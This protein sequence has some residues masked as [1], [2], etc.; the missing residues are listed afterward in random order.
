M[1]EPHL[2]VVAFS[3]ESFYEALS[4]PHTPSSQIRKHR[5]AQ[6]LFGY[7]TRLGAVSLVSEWPYTDGDYLD[8]FANYYVKCH[9]SYERRCKRL[10]FFRVEI[11]DDRLRLRIRARA[12]PE[13]GDDPDYLGFIVARPLPSAVVGRTV[14][15][16]FGDDGGRRNYTCKRGYKVNLCGVELEFDSLAFQEQDTILAACATV[17]LWSCFQ[18]TCNLFGTTSPTPA[19]ITNAASKAIHLGRPIP[20]RGLH[21]L[22]MCSAIRYVGLEPEVFTVTHKTPLSSLIYGYLQM[23]LPVILGVEIQG[24]GLHA[25]TITGYS[26][27]PQPVLAREASPK[28]GYVRLPGLRIDGFYGHDDQVGPFSR[29]DVT[30]NPYKKGAKNWLPI[31]F[32]S[33]WAFKTGEKRALYPLTVIV[34]VYHKIRLTF[35]EVMP[36]LVSLDPVIQRVCSKMFPGQSVE[37]DLYL[38][39]SNE[40]KTSLRASGTLTGNE[41]ERVLM[42]PHPRFLWWASV[43]IG[44]ERLVEFVFDA[45]DMARAFPLYDAIWWRPD[46][47]KEVKDIL[48]APAP[49]QLL[50][51]QP[52]EFWAKV[53][54][55]VH[56]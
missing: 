17:S 35:L 14:L 39:R 49:N 34:P 20:S 11:D 30:E 48:E 16:T 55:K 24:L 42:K 44:K 19:V 18:M 9:E 4:N 25:I 23:K 12:T 27:L 33:D 5:V 43:G 53:A 51:L 28:G 31:Y 7:L 36:W 22:E 2:K 56:L 38:R 3:E 8:D 13:T 21:V 15:R 10:H 41:L 37:W 45:T 26:M 52:E 32:E 46:F 54:A 40:Y 1:Q 29:L 6:Y 47:A 50:R